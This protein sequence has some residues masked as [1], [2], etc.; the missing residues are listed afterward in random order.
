MPPKNL[1]DLQAALRDDWFADYQLDAKARRYVGQFFDRKLAGK[2]LSAKVEGNHGAYTVSI[3][4][5][6]NG[7]DSACSCYIGRGGGCHHCD[8]LAQTFLNDAESFTVIK[9][10]RHQSVR[11]LAELKDYL[12]STTLE[13]L[14]QELKAQGLTQTAFAESIGMNP[15]H[16]SAIK[17]SEL[18]NRYF[19]EL[20]ATKLACLWVIE[21]CKPASSSRRKSR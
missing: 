12:A 11:T 20:G 2:K 1:D 21:N 3:T 8:A 19:N 18:R 16:L 4:A 6:A 15:R 14:L 7:F 13:A 10:Q 5:Q 9:Q 17:S